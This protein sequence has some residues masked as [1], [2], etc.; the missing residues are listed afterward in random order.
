MSYSGEFPTPV[1]QDLPPVPDWIQPGRKL[2]EYI[3]SEQDAITTSATDKTYQNQVQIKRFF[4]REQ[5]SSV[6]LASQILRR[7][8][9]IFTPVYEEVENDN[10]MPRWR[11]QTDDGSYT[12]GE[13]FVGN[14]LK[15]YLRTVREADLAEAAGVVRDT[16]KFVDDIL[17]PLAKGVRLSDGRVV[18][19][20]HADYIGY[21]HNLLLTKNKMIALIEL[22]GDKF[23]ITD[24]KADTNRNPIPYENRHK[25]M[26]RDLVVD[27]YRNEYLSRADKD[28]LMRD[29]NYEIEKDPELKDMRDRYGN[30][31]QITTPK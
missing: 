24:E 11:D 19:Y 29:Y 26:L 23:R 10:V 2:S 9:G 13:L 16:M 14:I 1:V 21:S 4:S 18:I 30:V 20:D 15:D 25:T 5:A 17:V 3:L 27:V 22:Q 8:L 28:R 7:D 6:V 12:V 31:K